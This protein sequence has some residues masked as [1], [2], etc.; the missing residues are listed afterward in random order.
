MLAT[1]HEN[2]Y[3]SCSCRHESL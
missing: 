2:G 3:S 1:L